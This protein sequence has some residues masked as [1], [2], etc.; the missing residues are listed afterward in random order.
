MDNDSPLVIV[1]ASYAGL[2][3]ATSA[4]ESG[5]RG[6]I[7]MVGEEERLPYQRPP[8]SKGLLTGKSTIDMLPLRS[9]TFYRDSEIETLL[10]RRVVRIDTA[11]RQVLLDDEQSLCY[12]WLAL[13]TGARCRAL[14]VP[15]AE[16]QGVHMLRTLDDSLALAR[17]AEQA[18]TACVI[19]GGFIG[20]EVAAA[21]QA[22]GLRVT[23]VEAQSRLLARSVPPIMSEYIRKAHESRG[24]RI[25][26]GRGLRSLRGDDGYVSSAELADGTE[27]P[28]DLVVVGIGVVPNDELARDAG[29]AVD[30]GILVDACGCTSIERVLAAGDVANMQLAGWGP[31]GAQGR[32]RLE[33]IQAANDTARACASVIVGDPKPCSAVPWFWSDQFNLKFQMAGV[34]LPTDQVIV[35][36]SMDNDKFCLIYLRAGQ[37][38]AVH[39]VNRPADHMLARRLIAAAAELSEQQAADEQFDLKGILAAFRP[40]P[41]AGT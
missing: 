3:L 17:H 10:G 12:G 29:I 2:Q 14:P 30:N 11:G 25:E 23:V 36:G 9:D 22:R 32:Y 4:R 31:H 41:P 13:A 20:L 27:I 34:P 28:C 15:G 7:V 33:S 18:K 8:L 37:V 21:L 39:T 40:S 6:R 1:G 24:V 5:Y 16:L 26:L 35:R 38:A 19:G